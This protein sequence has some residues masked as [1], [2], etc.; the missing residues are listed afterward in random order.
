MIKRH[1]RDGYMILL[2]MMFIAARVVLVTRLVQK[3]SIYTSYVETV[4]ARERAQNVAMSGLNIALA[5]LG[6]PPKKENENKEEGGKDE[7]P[8]KKYFQWIAPLI[9]YWQAYNFTEKNEGIDAKLKICICVESGKININDLYDF[10]EKKFVDEGGKAV[11][12][13]AFSK[14]LFEWLEKITEKNIWN[15]FEKILS[16][17]KYP[18]NDVTE[19]L[20]DSE[21]RKVF[22]DRIFIDSV[23]YLDKDKNEKETKS[24]FL[25][26]I[27]TVWPTQDKRINPWVLS[28]SLCSFFGLEQDFGVDLKAQRENAADWL[29]KFSA[30][31]NWKKDWDNSLAIKYKKKAQVLPSG[32]FDILS[33]KFE[34]DIFSVLCYGKVGQV[35][36][37][38]LVILQRDASTTQGKIEFKIKKLYW[39]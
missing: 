28:S 9:N 29:K 2:A 6:G 15:L 34:I 33:D 38:L 22:G 13:K 19:L 36:Q 4:C 7:D 31:S 21:I 3:C 30:S 5:Q 35:E 8:N 17:R 20:D 10:K 39:L 12:K 25:T 37:K 16:K 1:N 14:R 24:I 23:N 11:Y 26:D 18:F 32:F 27:F